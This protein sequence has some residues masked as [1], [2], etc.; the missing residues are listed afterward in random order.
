MLVFIIITLVMTTYW[1]DLIV[2]SALFEK[3]PY[4]PGNRLYDKLPNE[5]KNIDNFNKYI[6]PVLKIFTWKIFL[7]L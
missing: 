1:L 4:C 5:I 6:N 3:S 2:V 7:F